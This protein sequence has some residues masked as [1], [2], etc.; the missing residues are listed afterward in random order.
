MG[1]ESFRIQEVPISSLLAGNYSDCLYA[2]QE[3]TRNMQIST[4]SSLPLPALQ[5]D[6]QRCTVV[7]QGLEL[8]ETG[9]QAHFEVHLVDM[10]GDPCTTEQQVTAELRSFVDSSVTPTGV[11]HKTPDIY[12]VSY[13]P[14]TRG[15][16]ELSVRVNDVPVQGSPFLV[17]VRQAPHLLGRPVRVIKELNSPHLV[18]TT[19]SGELVVCEDYKISII[20]RDGERIRSIDTTSVRSGIRR[21]KLDPLGVAVDEDSN[22]YVT[23]VESH[24]LSKFNSKGKLVKSV[25]G[26]SGRTGQFDIPRG[27]ALSQDNKLFVCDSYNDRI[28]VFDTN[29]KFVFCFGKAGSGEGEMSYPYDLTFDPAGSVYVVDRGNDRVQVFSQNGTY[30]RAF[31]VYGSGPGELSSPWGIHVDHDHVYVAEGGNGRISIFQTSGAFITSFGRWGRGEG[32]LQDPCGITTDQDGFLYVCDIINNC[33]KV[34]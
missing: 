6:P 2:M 20:G 17:Y 4:T 34:F 1:R 21:Y 30:L 32:E 11:A 28:Q 25:G 18:A 3:V 27:I 13:Q 33:V 8:A 9:Q 23:D 14:N 15:R 7:G 31:G 29:L 5:P 19:T 26:E 22:I 16:H 12:E 24:R 10:A